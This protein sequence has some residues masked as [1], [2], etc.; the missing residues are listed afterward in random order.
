M[1]TKTWHQPSENSK[2]CALTCPVMGTHVDW[3]CIA[4]MPFSL[5]AC[6]INECIQCIYSMQPQTM[7]LIRAGG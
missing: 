4:A 6:N 3:G 5:A 1:V 2:S 7:Y